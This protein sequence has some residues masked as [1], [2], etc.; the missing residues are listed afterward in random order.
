MFAGPQFG[1]PRFFAMLLARNVTVLDAS[2]YTPLPLVLLAV[3]AELP[4]IVVCVIRTSPSWKLRPPPVVDT[5]LSLTVE[6][7]MV[8]NAPGAEFPEIMPPPASAVL[9]ERVELSIRTAVATM[10]SPPPPPDVWLFLTSDRGR[11]K[12]ASR[13]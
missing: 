1:L 8:V 7:T 6:L 4:A 3:E 9:W 11:T 13:G 5:E 2:V 10:A 12:E